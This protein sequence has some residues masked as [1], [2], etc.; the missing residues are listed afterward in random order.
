MSPDLQ[1]ALALAT[2]GATVV[3]GVLAYRGVISWGWAIATA[4]GALAAL[5]GRRRTPPA[6]TWPPAPTPPSAI[7]RTALR[8][9]DKRTAEDLDDIA[10]A[11]DETDPG[12]R[13]KR[14]AELDGRGRQ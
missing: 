14:I 9:S 4:T 11:N 10:A 8:E 6:P 2:V 7:T 3:L 1:L 12:E 13:L 5:L